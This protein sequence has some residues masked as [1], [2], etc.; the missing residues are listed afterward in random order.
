MR[1]GVSQMTNEPAE[2]NDDIAVIAS[3]IDRYLK[4]HPNAADSA[5]GI[6]RWWLA[7]QRY[8]ESIQKVE[9]ALALLLRQGAVSKRTLVDGKVLYVGAKR[10]PTDAH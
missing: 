6:L 2:V 8:E 10:S 9:Q 5:E 7:R 1:T 3:Q 4:S